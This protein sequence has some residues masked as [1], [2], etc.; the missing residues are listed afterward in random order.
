MVLIYQRHGQTDD[1]RSEDRVLHCSASRGKNNK[2]FTL[3]FQE[4]GWKDRPGSDLFCVEWDVK[5]QS[6]S[7]NLNQ[8]LAY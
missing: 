2:L 6:N 5:R 4:L 1:M 3:S 8:L 7:I